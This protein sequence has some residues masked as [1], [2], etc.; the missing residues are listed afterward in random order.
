MISVQHYPNILP[1]NIIS[2]ILE[3]PEVQTAKNS[4]NIKT[5]GSVSFSINLTSEIKNI[6][7]EKLGI[8]LLN[9]DSIPMRWIKGDTL[10]H[11]DSGYSSFTNT[12]LVYLTNSSGEFIVDNNSY[13]IS[14]GSAYV[15]NEGIYHETLG[16]GFEPRLLLGPMSETGFAVG[17]D[18]VVDVRVK[19]HF[20]LWKDLTR[21]MYNKRN[22]K[23]GNK[24]R[25][26]S[27][28]KSRT[29]ILDFL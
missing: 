6:I 13:P 29:T 2:K 12:Y 22:Y 3:L 25:D 27:F 14:K 18:P 4:I 16:T 24:K 23:L 10:P 28:D 7:L 20:N 19:Y 17:G 9:L 21:K 26:Y 5:S 8:N 11:I 1:E 15:F